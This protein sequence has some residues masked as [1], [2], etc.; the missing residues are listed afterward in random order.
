[1]LPSTAPQQQEECVRWAPRGHPDE[2]RVSRRRLPFQSLLTFLQSSV[3]VNFPDLL[4]P[5]DPLGSESNLVK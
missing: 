2:T 3:V 5:G 4:L 1:M